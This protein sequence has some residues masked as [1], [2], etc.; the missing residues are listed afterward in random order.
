MTDKIF[1]QNLQVET[2]IGVYPRERTVRQTLRLDLELACDI[3]RAAETDD[4][5]YALDYHAISQRLCDYIEQTEFQLIE[6]LA[7]KV[8]AILQQ[9]FGIRWLKLTLH[10]PGAVAQADSVGLIIERGE[11]Q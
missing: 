4:I 2:I 7:E 5:Q 3:S 11:K 9:E 1:I 8:V 6:T 10:K